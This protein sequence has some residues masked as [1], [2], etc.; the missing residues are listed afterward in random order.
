MTPDRLLSIT[1]AAQKEAEGLYPHDEHLTIL[2][3]TNMRRARQRAAHV[4][5]ALLYSER[6]AGLVEAAQRVQDYFDRE[7]P[8]EYESAMRRQLR[9]A[10]HAFN[11]QT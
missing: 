9:A 4:K 11:S 3:N 1:Q 5:C 8:G 2:T 10:L 6:A 7:V